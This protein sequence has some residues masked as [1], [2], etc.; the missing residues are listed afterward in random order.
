MINISMSQADISIYRVFKRAGLTTSQR[1]FSADW[2]G[3]AENYLGLRGHRGPSANILVG[4]FQRL[5]AR[6]RFLLAIRVAGMIL[7]MP[8]EARR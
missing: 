2:L 6:R 1:R 5:W 3:T 4:L 7:C 8:S